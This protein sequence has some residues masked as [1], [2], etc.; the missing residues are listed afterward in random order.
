MKTLKSVKFWVLLFFLISVS[1]NGFSQNSHVY[2]HED[3]LRG[4]ITPER[5]WWDVKHYTLKVIPDFD[6]R[7]ISGVNFIRFKTL[8]SDSIL[9]IDLQPDLKID[10]VITF[11]SVVK[12]L[13]KA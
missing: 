12:F 13:I 8:K 10:S 1:I 11:L 6:N 4:S 7:S 9:Q 5:A 2:N 3:T